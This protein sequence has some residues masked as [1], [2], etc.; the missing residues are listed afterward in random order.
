MI[1]LLCAMSRCWL[2][3]VVCLL[4]WSAYFFVGVCCSMWFVGCSWLLVVVSVGVGCWCCL[5][6]LFVVVCCCVLL[7]F[8]V[9]DDCLCMVLLIVFIV[10]VRCC[11]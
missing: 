5:L 3:F 8:V 1:L 2:L 9:I 7:S 4:L 10:V 11:F 6:L